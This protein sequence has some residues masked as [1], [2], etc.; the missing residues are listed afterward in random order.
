MSPI[1]RMRFRNAVHV[2]GAALIGATVACS[3]DAVSPFASGF[4]GGTSSNHEIGVVVNSTGKGLTLF[5]VGSPATQKQ[6]ALGTSS[7]V[8][9][10]G[11]A[12]RGRRAAI[13]LGNAASVALINLETATIQR[14]FTFASG[15]AT[16][17]AFSD[18][19][20]IIAAN[21]ALNTVGR[22]TVGQTGDAI[23]KSVSVAPQPTAVVIAGT[24]ALVVSGNLDAN[25]APIGNGI[26]TAIDP[27]T[28]QVLG[29]ATMG[30]TNS[31]DAAVG[32]DG[33][34]YVVNTGDFVGQGSLTIVTPATMQVVATIP[35]MG[36]GPGA[37]SIDSNG[38]AYIS[39]FFS[40]TLVWDTKTRAFVRG[41]NNPVCAK[42]PSG[43]CRGAFAATTNAAG[44]VYQ[45]FFGS[46][47][48]GLPP[49]LFVFKAG[50]FALTDS[51]SA[52][53]GPSALVIRT[54]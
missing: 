9:P 21:T 4:L 5:Q 18:D 33:L 44:D 28:M 11:L 3:S 53:V 19:T 14:F 34:V 39:G 35:G 20:T 51:I 26:L 27:S 40:G 41:T 32:P 29:T 49:Y 25:F 47:A 13:P 31:A 10:T 1:Y 7:T 22:A 2:V 52:G 16:G 46:S 12:V 50:T 48:Q 43:A 8:T 15:N 36:V 30:G 45:A 54:F 38:L 23:T 42:L 24:R 37:I 17:S 6:I